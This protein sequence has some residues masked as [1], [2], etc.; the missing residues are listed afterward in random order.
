MSWT[1]IVASGQADQLDELMNGA[2][3][4]AAQISSPGGTSVVYATSAEDVRKRRNSASGRMQLLIVAAFPAEP[5]I[6]SRSASRARIGTDQVD[7][8]GA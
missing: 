7:R 5:P 2:Q 6:E 8:S 4:I 3:E 1:I